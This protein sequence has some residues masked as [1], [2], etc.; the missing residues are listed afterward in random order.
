MAWG[1][2]DYCTVAELK[3]FMRITTTMDDVQ[4]SLAISTASRAVDRAASRQFGVVAAPEARTYE[5][6]LDPYLC[7][8]A[9]QV[10]D[11]MTEIGL[12]VG[13]G[14]TLLPRN[15]AQKG[16]PWTRLV[17]DDR[18]EDLD[19]VDIMARWGWTAVPTAVK[20]ATMLQASRLFKRKDAPFGI[21]GSPSEGSEMRLL[22]KVDPDVAVSVG[23]YIRQWGAV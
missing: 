12:V 2:T 16:R 17:L 14:Y 23:P 7:A 11:L 3:S 21:A 15:A 22:A 18:P 5:A 1:D 10:D 8:Y 19:A 6:R 20:L 4:L 9:V 13:G